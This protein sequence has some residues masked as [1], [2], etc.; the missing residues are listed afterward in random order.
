MSKAGEVGGI[1]AIIEA[2]NNHVKKVEVCKGG[3]CALGNMICD[4]GRR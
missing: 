2:I 3:C 4:N 1:E